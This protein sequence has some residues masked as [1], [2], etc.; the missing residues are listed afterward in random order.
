MLPS[1]R[2]STAFVPVDDAAENE[3]TRVGCTVA[4]LEV[5]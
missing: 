1:I 5:G 3:K 2:G 4:G